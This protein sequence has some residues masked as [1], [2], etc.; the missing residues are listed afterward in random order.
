MTA[1]AS[2]ISLETDT[3]AVPKASPDGFNLAAL[4]ALTVGERVI[5]PDLIPWVPY[6]EGVDVKPLRLNRKTG[7]WVNLTRV[8][9]GGVVSRHYHGSSVVGYVL[10]GS[11]YYVERDWVARPGSMI[12]EPPGDIHTL[13]TNPEGTTTLFLMEGPLFYLNDDDQV[14]GFDDVLT[15]TKMYRDYCEA[16]GIEALDLDY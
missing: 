16:N 11:W 10:E 9:G 15:F 7:I 3:S 6:I 13:V 1:L 5:D 2:D 12:W 4:S 8:V 14:I